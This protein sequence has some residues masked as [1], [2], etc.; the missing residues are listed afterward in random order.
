M[1]SGEPATSS[2]IA[3][4]KQLP[5]CDI[6]LPVLAFTQRVALV[7]QQGDRGGVGDGRRT[8]IDGDGAAVHENL[9]SR[10]AACHGHVIAGVAELRQ[11]LGGT[12][13][14]S[15]DRHGL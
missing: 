12:R 9:S 2:V 5:T 14:G 10:V 3:S 7:A 15:L 8:A 13:K 11:Q 6:S 1:A 4:Q